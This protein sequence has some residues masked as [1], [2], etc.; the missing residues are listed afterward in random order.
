[1][2]VKLY[3]FYLVV[4]I[5]V[6]A[7]YTNTALSQNKEAI[8]K[9]IP[10]S[11]EVFILQETKLIEMDYVAGY[12]KNMSSGFSSKRQLAIISEGERS[13][14]RINNNLPVF[15]CKTNP[16]EIGIARLDI[17]TY[18]G[19]PVRY[20]M[21]MADKGSTYWDFPEKNKIEFDYK[22]EPNGLY[23]LILKNP[24]ERGEY[25]IIIFVGRDAGYRVF[26]FAV[27]EP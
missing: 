12:T 8:T 1:M 22:K 9:D 17:D 14:L 19:K 2:K 20:V 26:D 13:K 6:L 4:N 18:K 5:F 10:S 27:G 3:F 23:K 11:G 21:A 16:S 7:I 24:L 15:Y 25:G